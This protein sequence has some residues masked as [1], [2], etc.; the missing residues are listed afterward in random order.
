MYIHIDVYGACS[1][2]SMGYSEIWMNCGLV[3][4]C[5]MVIDWSLTNNKGAIISG[6]TILYLDEFK[7][8]HCDVTAIYCIDDVFFSGNCPKQLFSGYSLVH[9]E[10]NMEKSPFGIGK[11]IKNGPFSIA[12]VHY[13]RVMIVSL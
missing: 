1:N 13:Q 7:L 9:I 3:L 12:M 4:H 6:C 11:S 10:K 2:P 8:T 5:P